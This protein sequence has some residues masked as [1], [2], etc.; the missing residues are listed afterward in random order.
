MQYMALTC[1]VSS[2]VA[3]VHRQIIGAKIDLGYKHKEM[4]NNI[5]L[6]INSLFH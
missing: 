2:L 1:I 6:K 4:R 3:A 5:Q